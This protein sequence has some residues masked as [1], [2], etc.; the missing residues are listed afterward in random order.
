MRQGVADLP[1]RAD[2]SQRTNERYLDALAQLDATTR[3][4]DIFGSVSRPVDRK[5][6]KARALR[7]WTPNDQNLLHA[8]SKPEFPLAGF[9]NADIARLLY[10]KEMDDP[11]QRR[12]AVARTSYHLKL[13]RAHGLISKLNK[14][15]RYRITKKGQQICMATAMPKRPRNRH[16]QK[17]PHKK[18][19]EFLH[20]GQN[21]RS[22]QYKQ[23]GG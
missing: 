23:A 15:R 1:A 18:A 2:K 21:L 3:L 6:K 11:K 20:I 10:P 9:R 4:E 22:G 13:L 7:L 12:S 17:L 8:I 19:K 16:L 5:K 14:T